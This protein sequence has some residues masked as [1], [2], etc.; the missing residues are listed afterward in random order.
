MGFNELILGGEINA[1][2]YCMGPQFICADLPQNINMFQRTDLWDLQFEF[3]SY[4][5]ISDHVAC[6]PTTR[7]GMKHIFSFEYIHKR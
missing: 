1:N 2:A 7:L 3:W 5:A 4:S 6:S